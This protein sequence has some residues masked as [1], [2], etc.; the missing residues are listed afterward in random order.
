MQRDYANYFYPFIKDQLNLPIR[1]FFRLYVAY[2]RMG[3]FKYPIFHLYC[4]VA[5]ILGEK[6]FDQVTKAIRLRLGRSPHFG[7]LGKE[8]APQLR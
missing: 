7:S 4:A 5:Y 8:V 2:G 3:F 6:R 1:K